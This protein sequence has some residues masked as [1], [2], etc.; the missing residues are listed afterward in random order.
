MLDEERIRTGLTLLAGI[1]EEEARRWAPLC[2]ACG[3]ELERRL[4][5][6]ANREDDRLYLAAAAEAAYRRAMILHS[7]QSGLNFSTPGLSVTANGGHGDDLRRLRDE[8]LALCGGL[9]EDDVVFAA[10]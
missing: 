2:K 9:L 6:G 8:M 10:V 5:A 4:R 1:G 7:G 3:E